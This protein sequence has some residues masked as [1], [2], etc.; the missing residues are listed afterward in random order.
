MPEA[1]TLAVQK[2]LEMTGLTMKDIAVAKNHNPFAVNDAIFSKVMDYDWRELNKTG[3]PLVWGHPQ[4]PT[5]MRVL[6]EALEEAVDLG[7]GYV[8]IFGC[9]AGDQGI[10]SIL[11]VSEGGG[12]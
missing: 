7:G 1:P 2:L 8:L 12:R 10:A 9:A 5:L 4:G 3:C 6:I 11:K